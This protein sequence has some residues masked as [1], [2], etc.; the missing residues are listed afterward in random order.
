M[1]RL[2]AQVMLLADYDN[3][4]ISDRIKYVWNATSTNKN[5]KGCKRIVQFSGVVH[6]H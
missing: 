4:G 1:K 6:L 5:V 3:V 2:L